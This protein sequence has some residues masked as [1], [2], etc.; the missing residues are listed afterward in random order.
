MSREGDSII[1]YWSVLSVYSV[2]VSI[3]SIDQKPV[4][5]RRD[6]ISIG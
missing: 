1:Q 5:A 3:F 6:I 4:P 2:L